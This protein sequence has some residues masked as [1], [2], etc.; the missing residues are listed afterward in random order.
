MSERDK[1]NSSTLMPKKI[2]MMIEEGEETETSSIYTETENIR[3]QEKLL[4]DMSSSEDEIKNVLLNKRKSTRKR[5]QNTELRKENNMRIINRIEGNINIDKKVKDKI[6]KNFREAMESHERDKWLEAINAEKASLLEKH[7]WEYVKKPTSE[8]ILR[9]NWKFV[10]KRDANGNVKK[11]K[12]RL[13]A[14]GSM[15]THGLDYEDS[16]SPV[17]NTNTIR[18]M[19]TLAIKRGWHM[20]QIDVKTAYLNGKLDGKT[21]MYIPEG[22]ERRDGQVCRLVRSLYGLC[23]S[24]LCW[25][26]ELDEKLREIGCC[27]G[28][29]DKCLYVYKEN[30]RNTYLMVYVDD[31]M[32]MGN[33]K[34]MVDNI[35]NKI[36]DKLEITEEEDIVKFLGI[37]ISRNDKCKGIL[38][39]EEYIKKILV[40]YSMEK[41]KGQYTPM[42]ERAAFLNEGEIEMELESPIREAIGMLGHL[43]NNTRPD[44]TFAVNKLA[45]YT[46]KPSR[47]VWARIKRIMRYLQKTNKMGIHISDT[48]EVLHAYCDADWATDT[49]DRKSYSGYVIFLGLTPII[50][51]T[52]KQ[53]CV[54]MST[55]EAEY[56]ALC[57][58]AKEVKALLNLLK[59]MELMEEKFCR[60]IEIRCDNT[61]AI[62]LAENKLI[63]A[64]TKHI[65]TRYHFVKQLI[66][67]GD[68]CVKYVPGSENVADTFTKPLGR[69]KFQMFRELLSIK[70]AKMKN[71]EEVMLEVVNINENEQ[72]SSDDEH[73][74][75]SNI[76]QDKYSM[77]TTRRKNTNQRN[78]ET[79]DDLITKYGRPFD[80]E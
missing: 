59:E 29:I 27:N 35:K 8:K 21:Y 31:I 48:S 56:V 9:S 30:G 51:K 67:D 23:Q 19:L 65:Q 63:S 64:R 17:V 50:W 37:G 47:E 54:S 72:G 16:Y 70:D 24:G 28:N 62:S 20:R 55:Q 2:N 4:S 34:R 80:D 57:D 10:K 75:V 36:K 14:D 61:S 12:A 22:F 77:T 66:E 3:P 44:I 68:I 45:Q 33:D 25:Y 60:R 11:F 53:E 42:E 40:K 71:E 15:Q 41:S 46:S 69:T 74:E 76:N 73:K 38:S 32:I 43:A 58:C 52:R 26:K 79:L 6:P 18:L 1:Q 13:V 5:K 49:M 39:Q 78:R 7:V